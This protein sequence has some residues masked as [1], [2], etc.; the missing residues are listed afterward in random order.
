MRYCRTFGGLFVLALIWALG[1]G[2][3]RPATAANEGPGRAARFIEDL[4]GQAMVALATGDGEMTEARR[5][6]LR[7]LIRKGFDLELTCQFV[8]GK[9]WNRAT[10]AERAEFRDLFSQYLVNSYARRLGSY[11]AETLSVVNSNAVGEHDILVETSVVG[12]DG[13]TNPVWRVRENGGTYKVI[14]VSA[15]GVSLALTH[16]REFA[17]VVNRVGLAGLLKVLREK[18][19]MEDKTSGWRPRQRGAH[20]SLLTGLLVSPNASP[21]S[22]LPASK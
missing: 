12:P 15:D 3:A 10:K 11:R 20:M 14:D 7:D 13:P 5:T 2:V 16:R 17:S 21:L 4:S 22:I 6:A 8:L 18:L 1:V 19:A 9:Y